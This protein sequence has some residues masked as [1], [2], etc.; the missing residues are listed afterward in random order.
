MQTINNSIVI[1][2][3]EGI[4]YRFGI[5]HTIVSDNATIFEREVLAFASKLGI[6]MTKSAPYY[7]KSIRQA[8]SNNKVLKE[9]RSNV[10]TNIPRV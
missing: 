3:L 6:T 1:K 9:N 7:A 4:V 10:I 8:E 5:P 2:F